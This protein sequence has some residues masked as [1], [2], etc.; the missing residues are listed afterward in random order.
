MPYCTLQDLIERYSSDELI[1]LTDDTNVGE[2]D[3]SV[4]AQAIADADGEIDGYLSGKF[5]APITPIPKPLV[6]IACDIARYYLYDDGATDQ[7]T[8][9]YNDAIA[10]LKG[11]AKGD[12]T[13]G[14]TAAG[15]KPA[16]QNTVRLESGGNVFNRK[17]KSFI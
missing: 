15:E 4:V 17:D 6:R 13:I 16:S 1:Q 9:R 8:K 10:F 14:V 2:I 5:A 11:V 3:E 12:I 7:V